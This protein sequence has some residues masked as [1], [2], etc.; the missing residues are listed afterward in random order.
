MNS[1]AARSADELAAFLSN[2]PE[3]VPAAA[4]AAPSSRSIQGYASLN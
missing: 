3:A 2:T 4:A 1:V